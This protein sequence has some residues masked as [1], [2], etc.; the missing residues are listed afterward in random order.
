MTSVDGRVVAYHEAG[1]YVV[2]N[3]LGLRT[4]GKPSIGSIKEDGGEVLG[5]GGGLEA[6]W[7]KGDEIREDR[8]RAHIV[9][10]YAGAAAEVRS[11]GDLEE[12]RRGAQDDDAMAGYILSFLKGASEA[13][14]RAEAARLVETL[15]FEIDKCA[16]GLLTDA[17]P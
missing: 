3:A 13:E 8:A 5:H 6:D 10:M 15:W 9:V 1:H 7:F 14:L 2:A 4:L 11:G 17:R 16:Q 12:A